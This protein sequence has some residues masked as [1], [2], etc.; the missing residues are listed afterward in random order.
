MISGFSCAGFPALHSWDLEVS[1]GDD[2]EWFSDISMAEEVSYDSGLSLTKEN[3]RL[4]RCL[5]GRSAVPKVLDA[6]GLVF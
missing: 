5:V 1:T 2:K 6:A 3:I 4:M